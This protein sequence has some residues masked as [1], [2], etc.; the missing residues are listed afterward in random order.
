M[1]DYMTRR[2]ELKN[3]IRMPDGPKPPKPLNKVS[4]KTAAKEK[5][6]KKEDKANGVDDK[7]KT[8]W[9]KARRREMVGVCQCGCARKSSKFEDD[10]FHASACHILPQRLFESVALHPLNCVERNFWEGCHTNMDNQSMDKW[11]M[12]ADWEDI[13]ER[14]YILAPLLTD[15][16]RAT[17]FY[18][19]LESLVYATAAKPIIITGD[20]ING[21]ILAIT[22]AV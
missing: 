20:E 9:F 8:K 16:E 22:Q 6:A 13:K 17:N 1:T 21:K 18:A 11:P 7:V 2:F 4:P 15:Q 12:F 5:A 10:N 19:H 3:G 14:F